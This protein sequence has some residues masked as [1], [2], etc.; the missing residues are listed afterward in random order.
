MT[1]NR[2]LALSFPLLAALVRRALSV[3]HANFARPVEHIEALRV[4]PRNA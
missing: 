2:L 4:E 1:H 3:N